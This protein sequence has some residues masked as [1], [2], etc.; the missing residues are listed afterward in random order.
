MDGVNEI[1]VRKTKEP[2]KM[3]TISLTKSVLRRARR[4]R[5]TAEML[6]DNPFN[7]KIGNRE[8]INKAITIISQFSNVV[9]Q[10]CVYD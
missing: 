1:I 3:M 10:C 7:G 9:T 4:N 2:R 5:N 8:Q 6:I